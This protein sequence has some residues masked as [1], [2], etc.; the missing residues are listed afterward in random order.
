[1][2]KA[3][4]TATNPHG[5]TVKQRL[6]ADLIASDIAD[7]KGVNMIRAHQD[8]YPTKN[9]NTAKSIAHSNGGI[10]TFRL[11]IIKGLRKKRILGVNGKLQQRLAEGLN[12][13]LVGSGKPALMIIL[14]YIKEINKVL[15]VYAPLRIDQ[16]T[17]N[18]KASRTPQELHD[19]I[20]G[21]EGE[22]I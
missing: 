21:L 7:G 19:N 16:R 14:A 11:E 18:L 20:V 17:F 8:I 15:G 22:L 10:A 5:L 13:K 12:A 3:K 6:T 4:V 9:K 2:P 1:M